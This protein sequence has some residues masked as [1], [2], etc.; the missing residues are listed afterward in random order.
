MK[1]EEFT[2]FPTV[3]D[4]IT[5]RVDFSMACN[6]FFWNAVLHDFWAQIA[7]AVLLPYLSPQ[8]YRIFIRYELEAD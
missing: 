7:I 1:R 8:A 4:D 5:V 2:V 6:A 3:L